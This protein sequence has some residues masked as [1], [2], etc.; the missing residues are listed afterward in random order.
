VCRSRQHAPS[1]ELLW[2][3]AACGL[4]VTSANG[5]ILK[6]NNTFCNWLGFQRTELVGNQHLQGLLS[7][8]GRIFHQTHWAPLLQIQGS[9]AEVK[10]DVLH[11]EGHSIPMMLNAVRR[12]HGDAVFHEVAVFVAEDRHRYESEILRHA[13]TP[14]PCLPTSRRRRT[15]S[16]SPRRA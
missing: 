10:L 5:L 13:R 2:D 1:A 3:D 4:L 16:P 12:Q 8:S 15:R 11:A 9:V 6:V 7:I 14:R